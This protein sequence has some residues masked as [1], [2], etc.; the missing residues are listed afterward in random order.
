MAYLRLGNTRGGVG[1]LE[2]GYLVGWDF[3]G[4]W[5]RRQRTRQGAAVVWKVGE[6][7]GGGAFTK[8]ARQTPPLGIEQ[9]P[10]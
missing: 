6:E 5:A 7:G 4:T 3:D 9:P 8:K 1:C 2:A 10:L